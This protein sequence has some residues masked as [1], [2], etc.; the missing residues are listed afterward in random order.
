MK[1]GRFALSRFC[2]WLSWVILS[3]MLPSVHDVHGGQGCVLELPYLHS[4]P[5]GPPTAVCN[6]QTK[7]YR[8]QKPD[9]IGTKKK[10]SRPVASGLM[11]KRAPRA[12]PAQPLGDCVGAWKTAVCSYKSPTSVRAAFGNLLE[13]LAMYVGVHLYGIIII[14]QRRRRFTRIF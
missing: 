2:S 5:L 3:A 9:G 10:L 4:P 13:D 1:R 11:P 12:R 14:P 7:R 6:R 8:R